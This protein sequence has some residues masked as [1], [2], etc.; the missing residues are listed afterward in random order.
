MSWTFQLYSA[1]NTALAD[2]LQVVAD[3]GYTSVEAYGDNFNDPD[4]LRAGL[5]KHGLQLPSLHINLRPLREEPA[6]MIRR[7]HDF[8]AHHVVCPFLQEQERPVDSTGWIKQ[9]AELSDHAKRWRD[10]GFTF[11]WHNHD[12]E[13]T[14]LADGAMPMQLIL[15]HAAELQWEIDIAWIVRAGADPIPWVENNLSRISAAHLKDLAPT[16]ECAAEDGW[17][18]LGYGVVP[19][20]S[21]IPLL[22]QTPATVYAMEHDNPSDLQRFATRSIATA[23]SYN[24]QLTS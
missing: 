23:S 6:E 3:A 16:G 22:S 9:I 12:F 4:A 15:E 5:D 11:A 10:A 13:F 14:A 19:W 2:A 7:A 18:D 17:A 8:G 20:G 24:D 1:R 21:V